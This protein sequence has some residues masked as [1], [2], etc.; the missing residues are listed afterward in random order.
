MLKTGFS[1][2]MYSLLV[3]GYW[4]FHW[5]VLS[6]CDRLFAAECIYNPLSLLMPCHNFPSPRDDWTAVPL[7]QRHKLFWWRT[8]HWK[9]MCVISRQIRHISLYSYLQILTASVFYP[10]FPSAELRTHLCREK[11]NLLLWRRGCCLC[12]RPQ[13]LWTL[14]SMF[15]GTAMLWSKF[16]HNLCAL[17]QVAIVSTSVGNARTNTPKLRMAWTIKSSLSGFSV[18]F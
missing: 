10:H 8:G 18:G 14:F 15:V 11:S 5:D 3:I 6:T 2:E 7:Q 16:P 13:L 9:N 17:C 12:C 1:N 4:L